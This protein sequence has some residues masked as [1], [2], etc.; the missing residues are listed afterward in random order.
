[1][2]NRTGNVPG[3]HYAKI[4]VGNLGAT[5]LR[6]LVLAV[7]ITTA[8]TYEAF[9]LS[10]LRGLDVWSHLST[11]IWISQNH[12]VP[13]N[14]LFS[15]YPDLSWSAHSW[16]FDAL[17]AAVYKLMGLRALPVS[18]MA[19][20]VALALTF[21]LLARGSRENF[22]PAVV[23]A[24][25][26][27]Y[28]IPGLQLQPALCSILLYSIELA[29]LFHARRTGNTRPLFWLP[30]LFVIW[31]NLDIGFIFGLLV[32]ALLL[33]LAAVEWIC[34]RYRVVW[35]AGQMQAIPLGMLGVMTA[36]SLFA[37]LLTPYTFDVYGSALKSFGRSA[38]LVYLP[39]FGAVGFRQ[40][41]DYAL[42]L[43][44]MMAF[45]SLGRRQ[46]RDLFQFALMIVSAILS[47]PAQRRL[48]AGC[49]GIGGCHRLCPYNQAHA[50]WARGRGPVEAGQSC[51]GRGCAPGPIG[52][53]GQPYSFQPRRVASQR[54]QDLASASL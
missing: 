45:F 52:G 30:L 42:L 13:H 43:L 9:S 1:M 17:L 6:V 50:A 14:G 2:P 28:A 36:A 20:K 54:R 31:A 18:L 7:L 5:S 37:T 47:F 3:L 49:G 4:A 12:A 24:A 29:L 10:A 51:H 8:A 33:A 22:W 35:F 46:S 15:Q 32:L 38:L 40:P 41:Q 25:L 48:L 44:T 16:G 34:R 26:A 21:F 11:G 39:E 23:L 27:Q 19:L 53:R